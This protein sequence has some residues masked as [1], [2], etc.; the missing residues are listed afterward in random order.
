MTV[1]AND[2]SPRRNKYPPFPPLS[3]REIRKRTSTP[4]L[5]CERDEE[6]FSTI[7]ERERFIYGDLVPDYPELTRLPCNLI[8]QVEIEIPEYPFPP[9]LYELEDINIVITE[10]HVEIAK[11]YIDF[12]LSRT[13]F[14]PEVDYYFIK[15]ATLLKTSKEYNKR[16]LMIFIHISY[17][18]REEMVKDSP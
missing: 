14:K 9:E 18:I 6:S 5:T 4:Y 2:P 17:C 10:K 11:R 3:A 13:E 8:K 12:L 15:L 1:N 16:Q 7:L